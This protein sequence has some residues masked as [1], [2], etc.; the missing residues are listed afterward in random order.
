M[1]WVKQLGYDD[2]KAGAKINSVLK[3]NKW[4]RINLHMETNEMSEEEVTA[5]MG[6]WKTEF[7][8]LCKRNK[9]THGCVYNADQTSLFQKL[10]YSLY[11]DKV[12]KK[13]IVGFK[14]MKDKAQVT[15]MVCTSVNG[16]RASLVVVGK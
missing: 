15:L 10:P 14:Q 6:P 16:W 2:F 5:L 12:K 9:V 1:V 8:A 7:H 3:R 11:V 4:T 13:K